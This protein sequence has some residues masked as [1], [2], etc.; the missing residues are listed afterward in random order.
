MIGVQ[1]R[2]MSTFTSCTTTPRL[3]NTGDEYHISC[4][5]I[6]VSLP[7]ENRCDCSTV[8]GTRAVT[9][10]KGTSRARA[11]R[12]IGCRC[13]G[14][15]HSNRGN[16]SEF[17]EHCGCVAESD[18]PKVLFRL[19]DCRTLRLDGRNYIASGVGLCTHSAHHQVR[20]P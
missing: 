6:D 15:K 8:C 7:S 16:K 18:E 5:E 9:A 1:V 20:H 19:F 11:C 14:R 17:R 12:F 3:K 2:P 4:S 13:G 10:L